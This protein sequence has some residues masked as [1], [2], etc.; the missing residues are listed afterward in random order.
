MFFLWG[1]ACVSLYS[2]FMLFDDMI[3]EPLNIHLETF[4]NCPTMSFT[5]LSFLLATM[6]VFWSRLPMNPE[7]YQA[8]QK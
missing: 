7:A 1:D 4:S 2:A 8:I 5:V 3:Y 6:F